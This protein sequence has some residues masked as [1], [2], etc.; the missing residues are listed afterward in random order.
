MTAGAVPAGDVP[1]GGVPAGE[2]AGFATPPDA[3]LPLAAPG[4]TPGTAPGPAAEAL[5]AVLPAD[6]VTWAVGAVHGEA[7]RLANLHAALAERIRPADNL[8]Y[9]GNL[10]GR[11]AHVGATVEAV[12]LFRRWLM[13]RQAFAGLAEANAGAI[14]F[15]RGRQ[16]EMWHKLLQVQFAP[17]PREVLEWMLSHGV[18]ATLA[19]YGAS[20]DEAR[21]AGAMGAVGLSQWTNRLRA[22]MRAHDG[23]ERLMTELRRAAFTAD[24]RVLLVSAGLDPS[25]PLSEQNDTFWWGGRGFEEIEPGWGGF[26]RIVRGLDPR[27]QGVL[28]DGR[29]ATLDAGAGFGGGLVAAAF[30]PAGRH[31][32]SIEA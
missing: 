10:L 19:T 29:I 13:A 12:L 17:N 30:D 9:L 26:A 11:G 14:A 7:G 8:V 20:E 22:A 21:R 1:A 6:R 15:L 25:R 18:G 2:A 27:Q 4:A 32:D 5:F 16:E 23:H 28:I 3:A 31:I 24:G